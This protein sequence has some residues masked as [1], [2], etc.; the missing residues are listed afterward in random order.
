MMGY[1][2]DKAW[3]P[4]EKATMIGKIHR[5]SSYIMILFANI[6]VSGGTITYSLKSLK[7]SKFI[8]PAFFNFLI[9]L[10]AI[11]ISEYCYRRKAGSD[12]LVKNEKKIE[13]G[14]DTK[15]IK[16]LKT[17]TPQMV[18]KQVE[19]GKP[20]VILDNLVLHTNGY[21]K[22]HPGGKFTLTKNYGRDVSKFFY[23]GYVLVNGPG[24]YGVHTHS[25]ASRAIVRNMIVGCL[26][27]QEN[28]KAWETTISRR[29]SVNDH[30][31][32]FILSNVHNK[33]VPNFRTWYNDLQTIGKH[34]L[35]YS[36]AI[37]SVKRHYTVCNSMR[38]EILS[39]LLNLA[40]QVCKNEEVVF[41]QSILVD[42]DSP[43]MSVT[44]KNYR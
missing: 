6:V 31:S 35:I 10:N 1:S 5:Y 34:F 38:P 23:G 19:E 37:P 26:E 24:S 29:V 30:T 8:P 15:D 17:Y 11:L 12:N 13:M 40:D 2:K 27:G 3:T 4:Q 16:N 44:V 18:D 41:D 21:E 28:I 22:A 43:S 25:E 42:E 36:R 20:L 7:T 33:N 9:F 39:E 14:D 32:C